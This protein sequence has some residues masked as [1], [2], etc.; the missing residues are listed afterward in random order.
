[1]SLDTA[2]L[3]RL[4]AEAE[5]ATAAARPTYAT[6]YA[7]RDHSHEAGGM[8]VLRRAEEEHESALGKRQVATRYLEVAARQALPELLD[9]AEK[10]P[11]S[12]VPEVSEDEA[13][14]DE[15]IGKWQDD[16]RDELMDGLKAIGLSGEIDGGGCDSGDWRDFTLAEV[17]D[18]VRIVSDWH[19][20][21]AKDGRY[22]YL[23]GKLAEAEAKS[24]MARHCIATAL[25]ANEWGAHPRALLED[26]LDELGGRP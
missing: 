8:D 22:E 1:M 9:I 5:S 10:V 13:L 6:L 25:S 14:T 12:A 4:M 15:A 19:F 16:V 7:A 23:T 26:A 17:R 11:A 20:D 24:R 2:H 18:F 3:R 21:N